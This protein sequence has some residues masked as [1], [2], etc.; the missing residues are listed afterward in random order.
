MGIG[1]NRAG[2]LLLAGTMLLGGEHKKIRSDERAAEVQNK[3]VQNIKDLL[4]DDPE[5]QVWAKELARVYHILQL[6]P[7]T[8][9][10]R[11]IFTVDKNGKVQGAIELSDIAADTDEGKE[12]LINRKEILASFQ[13]GF[14]SQM[15]VRGMA[16]LGD[17]RFDIFVPRPELFVLDPVSKNHKIHCL[18]FQ[19]IPGRQMARDRRTDHFLSD[20][21]RNALRMNDE[22]AHKL[23]SSNNPRGE[24]IFHKY[25]EALREE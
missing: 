23:L 19:S 7:G 12:E 17:H 5:D 3:T 2:S 6:K 4:N 8:E 16:N 22:Q 18:I 11:M 9:V 1:L 24:R 25:S 15:K 20:V 14:V 13:S 10:R 21:V